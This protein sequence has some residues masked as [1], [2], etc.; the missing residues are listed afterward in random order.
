VYLTLFA[1]VASV[2]FFQIAEGGSAA[3]I[4]SSLLLADG[5]LLI[6][7]KE[8]IVICARDRSGKP[9]AAPQAR[10]GLE[11]DSPVFSGGPEK[12]RPV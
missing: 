4:A 3:W 12:M 7:Q 9:A 1:W 2:L 11:A 8:L 5:V 6:S 10:R